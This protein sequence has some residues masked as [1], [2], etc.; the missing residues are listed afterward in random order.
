MEPQELGIG[1]INI[2]KVEEKAVGG[3]S[4][5]LW[6]GSVEEQ[7]QLRTGGR[8]D[9]GHQQTPREGGQETAVVMP[10][11]RSGWVLGL[12][13]APDFARSELLWLFTVEPISCPEAGCPWLRNTATDHS[14]WCKWILEKE[15]SF[16]SISCF[17]SWQSR[18]EFFCFFSF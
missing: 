14:H 15:V 8:R 10:T 16:R 12:A 7:Q 13:Q 17:P 5:L 6:A 4:S 9:G 11:Q 18:I 1:V 3:Q 2:K